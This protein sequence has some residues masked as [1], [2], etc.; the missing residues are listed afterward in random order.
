M[1]VGDRMLGLA[2]WARLGEHVPFPHDRPAPDEKRTEMR[3]RR[4]ATVCRSD[5]DGQAVRWD[6]AGER[7]LAGGRRPHPLSVPDRD[8]D[9]PVLPRRVLVVADRELAQDRSIDRPRPRC[10]AGSHHETEGGRDRQC[11]EHPQQTSSRCPWSEH[12]S[13]VA[14]GA[15]VAQP[16]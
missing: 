2:R 12:G 13:T 16:S 9:A 7:D 15:C 4:L 10:G 8:I 5:R 11:G 6:G 14:C 1:D 3:E